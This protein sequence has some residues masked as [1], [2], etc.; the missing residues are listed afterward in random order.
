MYELSLRGFQMLSKPENCCGLKESE[1]LSLIND[2]G[3]SRGFL[4]RS[5][6]RLQAVKWSVFRSRLWDP[7]PAQE[8]DHPQRPQTREHRAAGYRWKGKPSLCGFSAS[9]FDCLPK[10]NVLTRTFSPRSWFT[11]SSIWATLRTWIRA[12]C[13][14]LLLGRCS[15]W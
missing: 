6:P 7:V 10:R 2:V 13:A 8:Q 3:M 5:D 15:I 9:L 14:P 4:L 11:R 12:A 1:V